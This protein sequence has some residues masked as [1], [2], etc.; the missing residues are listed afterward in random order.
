MEQ[1]SLLSRQLLKVTVQFNCNAK[2]SLLHLC[3]HPSTWCC[4]HHLA[5]LK[6]N[7]SLSF[8]HHL[9]NK[10]LN[11]KAF[12]QSPLPPGIF[13]G[14]SLSMQPFLRIYPCWF[15][16]TLLCGQPCVESHSWSSTVRYSEPYTLGSLTKYNPLPLHQCAIQR[17]GH[18]QVPC[19]G[20]VWKI[21]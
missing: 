16:W 5:V 1:G 11:L 19:H 18:F 4:H 21:Q 13:Q 8:H 12:D 2:P 10:I 20:K 14:N 9:T 17:S 7:I 15:Q 6:N 3:S